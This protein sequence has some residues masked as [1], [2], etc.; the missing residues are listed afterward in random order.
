MRFQQWLM[1]EEDNIIQ[2]AL[3]IEEPDVGGDYDESEV[4]DNL[5]S[6]RIA[7]GKQT[8]AIK[9]I[10]DEEELDAARSVLSDLKDAEEKWENWKEEV[11][12]KGP[13]PEP[14]NEPE[15]S[16]KDDDEEEE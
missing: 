2:K 4:A 1:N 10:K 8:E 15:N 16:D 12:S 14:E 3:D 6:L 11:K 7:I 13:N 5:E 9:N